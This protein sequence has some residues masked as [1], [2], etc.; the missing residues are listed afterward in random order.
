MDGF[1]DW[2]FRSICR[3]L[4]SALSY[5]EFVNAR[6]VLGNGK[7]ARDK[8]RFSE[9]ERPVVFQ[10]YGEDPDELVRAA[11]QVRSLEPD[12]IDINMGCPAKSI[13]NRGAGVG[14]MRTPL[15]V[16]R[17]FRRLAAALDIPVTAKIRLGWEDCKNYL[18]IARII[19]ENGGQALAVHARTRE[20]G[21]GGQA[22][23]EAIAEIRQQ[24]SIPLI[25]NGDV[26]TPA[27]ADRMRAQTGC[28]AVMVGRAAIGNPWIFA[29][30]RREE[31]TLDDLAALVQEHLQRSLAFYGSELGMVLFRKHA[32]QYI[33]PLAPSR[34]ARAH[35]LRAA[36]AEIF[37]QR[38][39]ELL[40]VARAKE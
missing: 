14:L 11:L 8:L 12:V 2:P 27:D 7:Y 10:L 19:E 16:A 23:W 40:A 28:E 30:R 21:Y 38:F 6:E 29:G 17:L 18:L 34:A 37:W 22:D 24:I 15:K 31:V 13:A 4:G 26:Q 3:E 35:L 32:V 25:G 39:T 36:T 20:Q 9:D 5:T 33:R 1:S